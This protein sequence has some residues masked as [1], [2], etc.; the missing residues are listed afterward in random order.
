MVLKRAG[1]LHDNVEALQG[2]T[3]HE[4]GITPFKIL[5]VASRG[6][7]LNPFRAG[8]AARRAVVAEGSDNEGRVHEPPRTRLVSETGGFEGNAGV[9]RAQGVKNLDQPFRKRET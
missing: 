5:D 9:S 2:G 4:K 7:G 3:G 1:A 6:H 8:A